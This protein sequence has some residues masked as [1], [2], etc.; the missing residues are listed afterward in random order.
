MDREQ[1]RAELAAQQKQKDH[2]RGQ[3]DAFLEELGEQG[4]EFMRKEEPREPSHFKISLGAAAK[5]LEKTAVPRRTAA[6]VENLL[7]DE[8]II[9]QSSS[10]RKPLIPINFDASVRAN[11]TQEEIEEATRQLAREIPN[12]REGLWKWP[13]SW[14]HLTENKIDKDIKQWAANKV[15]EIMGLQEDLLVDAIVEH[16]KSRR[17]PQPLVENLEVVSSSYTLGRSRTYC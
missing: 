4:E 16:L 14:D 13:V 2:A 17:G 11:L 3:A 6:D 8:E 5:K 1:E 7:E 12:D 10:K 9:D 15:L